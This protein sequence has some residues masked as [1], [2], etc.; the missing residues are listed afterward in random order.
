M[1]YYF[2]QFAPDAGDTEVYCVSFPDF[3][4]CVAFGRGFSDAMRNAMDSLKSRIEDVI[5]VNG[6]LPVP[7]NF[8]EAKKKS[9]EFNEKM[10][11]KSQPG[12]VYLLVPADADTEPNEHFTV[13]MKRG[14][15]S[16]I[17]RIA[18][19]LGLT[20]SGIVAIMAREYISKTSVD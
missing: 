18:G 13:S 17:D 15:L 8:E 3:P 4:G 20:R 6:I 19:K 14:L 12:T 5:E 16:K 11:I 7:S 10:L 1:Y 2:A 9:Q